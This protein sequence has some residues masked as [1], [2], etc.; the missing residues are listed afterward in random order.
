MDVYDLSR[1]AIENMRPAD[2][3]SLFAPP[4]SP[5]GEFTFTTAPAASPAS[6]AHRPGS[7]IPREMNY[8]MSLPVRHT[9]R[10]SRAGVLLT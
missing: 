7:A 8:C 1:A 5:I 3:V 2:L 6:P 9:S 4:T 10:C